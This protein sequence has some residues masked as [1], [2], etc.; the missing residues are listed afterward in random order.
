MQECIPVISITA[1][2]KTEQECE[3]NVL[4]KDIIF[5]FGSLIAYIWATSI[6][7]TCNKNYVL[8]VHL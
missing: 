7:Q 6:K 2:Q 8:C 4:T 3:L 5:L 1:V